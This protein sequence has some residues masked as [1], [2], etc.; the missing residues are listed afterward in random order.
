MSWAKVQSRPTPGPGAR[1]LKIA[2]S[3]FLEI[4]ALR[5][6]ERSAWNSSSCGTTFLVRYC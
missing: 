5:K 2:A 3:S 6:R 4:G 1:T